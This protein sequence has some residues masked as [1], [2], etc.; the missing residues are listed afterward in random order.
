MGCALGA[1]TASRFRS[2][3]S[4]F[5]RAEHVL[6]VRLVGQRQGLEDL[7]VVVD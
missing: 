6:V 7:E 1:W 2:R 4:Y 5:E 3:I